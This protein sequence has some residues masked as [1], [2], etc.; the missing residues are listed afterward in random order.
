VQE[1]V[2]YPDGSMLK[3]TVAKWYTGKSKSTIDHIGVRP[4]ITISDDP[5]TVVDEQLAKA[6][7]K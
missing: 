4:D 5:K 2:Q 3:Y 6:L 7:S 1:L